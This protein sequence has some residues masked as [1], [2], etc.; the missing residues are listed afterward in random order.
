MDILQ[1]TQMVRFVRH[2]TTWRF[3]F[4]ILIFYAT[5][6]LFQILDV[7]QFYDGFTWGYPGWFS[8]FVPYSIIPD[9]YFSGHVGSCFIHILEFNAVG[10]HW[11]SYYAIFVMA[12][13][14]F[15]LLTLRVHYSIDMIGGVLFA[16][17]IWIMSSRYCYLFDYYILGI[18][19]E[20]R[21]AT[22]D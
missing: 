1:L 13:Q 9:F 16:H 10:W 5:R 3:V 4:A 2:G 12:C 20:K 15:T 22:I 14:I 7:F 17:Y 19:L 18:P 11:A 21:I 8:L 6:A